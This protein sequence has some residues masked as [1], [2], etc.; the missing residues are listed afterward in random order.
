MSDDK[1][2]TRREFVE[3]TTVVWILTMEVNAYDQCGEYFVAVYKDK[4]THQ[5]LSE[6]DVPTNRLRHVLDGGGRKDDEDTW[7]NLKLTQCL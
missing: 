5:Q 7:Y 3:V 2:M 1:I 4:P 6:Q